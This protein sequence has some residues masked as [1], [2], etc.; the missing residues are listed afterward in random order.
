MLWSTLSAC[1]FIDE[2]EVQ[3]FAQFIRLCILIRNYQLLIFV[4]RT[5]RPRWLRRIR[6]LR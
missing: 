5:P 4:L 2:I 6:S 1:V 3:N